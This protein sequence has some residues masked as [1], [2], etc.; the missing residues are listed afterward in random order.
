MKMY[1]K[2]RGLVLSLRDPLLLRCPLAFA[3][4]TAPDSEKNLYIEAGILHR[5]P[6]RPGFSI[7]QKR[8]RNGVFMQEN[9]K[10]SQIY[11]VNT[12]NRC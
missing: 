10:L 9:G 6:L 7:L 3:R 2:K 4:V 8:L 5:A 1:N 11:L 12:W